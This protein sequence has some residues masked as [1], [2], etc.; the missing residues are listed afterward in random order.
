MLITRPEP[1]ASQTAQTLADQ[2]WPCL[3]A[4]M[5]RIEMGAE[6]PA[7]PRVQAVLVTSANALVALDQIDRALP[8]LAVGD[9]TAGRALAAGFTN[10]LSAGRDAV[11]LAELATLQLHPKAGPLLLVCGAGQGMTL[12]RDLRT[13]GFVVRRRIAYRS[14]SARSLSPTIVTALLRNEVQHAMFFSAETA[15]AFVGCIKSHSLTKDLALS[16]AKIDALVI[17]AQTASALQ[18]L[19]WRSIRVASHPNQDELV[20]LLS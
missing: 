4:P 9:A 5:L 3:V 11:A 2:G 12:A 8:L 19:P 16:L 13:R 20:G 1:A 17:S 15:R 7:L 6:L 18:A 10:V 14:R